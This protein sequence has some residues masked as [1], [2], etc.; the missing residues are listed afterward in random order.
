M[1]VCTQLVDLLPADGTRGP[2]EAELKP[3]TR[4]KAHA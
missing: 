4:E 1:V 3:S 2:S